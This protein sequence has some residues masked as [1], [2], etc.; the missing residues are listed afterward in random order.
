LSSFIV[1]PLHSFGLYSLCAICFP[2]FSLNLIA[3]C[4]QTVRYHWKI[5][6]V[7]PFL[8]FFYH[9]V[10]GAGTLWGAIRIIVKSTPVQ[11]IKEP[12]PGAGYY[13]VWD[14]IVSKRKI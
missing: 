9:I 1:V 14:V 11:K 8:F 13:R 7:L 10:Y 12:W 6:L 4:Q 5:G 2:Y 3:S